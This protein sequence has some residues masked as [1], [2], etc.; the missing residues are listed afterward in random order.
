[1]K[2]IFQ[3]MKNFTRFSI[4]KENILFIDV[5]KHY[6]LKIGKD[7]NNL[8]FYCQGQQ[9]ILDNSTK[10]SQI[11]QKFLDNNPNEIKEIKILVVDTSKNDN[12]IQTESENIICPDCHK[13]CSL[14]FNKNY[15][16]TYSC[17]YSHTIND[18]SYDEY[19][20]SL[21]IDNSKILCSLCKNSKNIYT[22]FY[23]CKC[24][25]YLC[26][27]CINKHLK[28]T[29]DNKTHVVID[30][31]K[32]NSICFKHGKKYISNK[33]NCCSNLCEICNAKHFDE[34]NNSTKKEDIK[35]I[36]KNLELAVDKFRKELKNIRNLFDDIIAQLELKLFYYIKLNKMILKN[37][38]EY[39]DGLKICNNTQ[40]IINFDTKI[41][42]NIKK[43]LSKKSIKEKIIS[44]FEN[45]NP[46]S[47]I[48]LVYNLN[49]NQQIKLFGK[50]FVNKNLNNCQLFF[51][52]KKMPLQPEI[53][54]N[55]NNNYGKMYIKLEITKKITDMSNMFFKCDNLYSISDL[56]KIKTTNIKKINDLFYG[57]SS[58]KFISEDISKW[59]TSNII[60]MSNLFNGCTSLE[61]IPDISFWNTENV[62]FMN[63]IFSHCS[64]LKSL[65]DIS[66][67]NTKNVT[68]MHSM[69]S[70]CLLLKKIPNLGLWSINEVT[71]IGCMF[72][73]CENLEKLPDISK[74]KTS[75]VENMCDLFSGCKN[76]LSIPDIS[77]WDVNNV[78]NMTYMF[79]ECKKLTSLPN[80]AKWN[81]EKLINKTDKEGLPVRQ[82]FEMFNGVPVKSIPKNLRLFFG[83]KEVAGE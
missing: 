41:I 74:W 26:P 25:Y 48:T 64:N 27:L 2:I 39:N 33:Y 81:F 12:I 34:S 4:Q 75:N 79:N 24:G 30:F 36:L 31:D 16:S 80:L 18:I 46:L 61:N 82:I 42:D 8:Y 56:G 70:N 29:K 60:D 15:L 38:N 1:M 71:N 57:C 73:K 9:I 55:N 23:F 49:D 40:N 59:D 78:S 67:W 11:V 76:L 22:K 54:L 65:P 14:K 53:H 20:K 77:L 47:S 3:Y 51:N 45:Y 72:E 17:I 63:G 66:N 10:F 21:N 7:I 68:N 58:L 28:D 52:G 43:F 32:K 50:S 5:V 19:F 69:F 62:K 35:K 6:T 83:I 37:I 44:L 13:I